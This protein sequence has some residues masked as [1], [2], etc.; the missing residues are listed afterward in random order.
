MSHS[1]LK[2]SLIDF[3]LVCAAA[4]LGRRQEASCALVVVRTRRQRGRQR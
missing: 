3:L 2:Q 4:L 1:G